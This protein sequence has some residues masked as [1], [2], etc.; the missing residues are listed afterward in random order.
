MIAVEVN[1]NGELE[2]AFKE[3]IERGARALLVAA[4]PVYFDQRVRIAAFAAQNKIPALYV[5]RGYP[6]AGGLLSYG[7][8][9]SDAYRQLG[10]YVGRI[11]SGAKPQELPV[12]SPQKW[13]L[14][15]NLKVARRCSLRFKSHVSDGRNGL[16]ACQTDAVG[17]QSTCTRKA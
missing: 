7:P 5:G 15:I 9:I 16:E 3:I 17:P 13:Q 2:D 10:V 11:L 12:V 4:D 8:S 14:V 1:P 6:V